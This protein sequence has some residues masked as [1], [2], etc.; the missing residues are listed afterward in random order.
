[1]AEKAGFVREGTLRAALAGRNGLR[2]TWVGALLP[3]DL[4]LPFAL[5]CC[6]AQS[7]LPE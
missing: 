3:A 2:D 4:G 5:P 7:D 6:P 1:M